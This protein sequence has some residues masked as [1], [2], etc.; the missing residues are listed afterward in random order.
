MKKGGKLI[1]EELISLH[2]SLYKSFQK[3]NFKKYFSDF[4]FA[5]KK[6]RK[7]EKFS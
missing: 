1:M 4:S 2:I 6:L 5:K 7:N 3:K